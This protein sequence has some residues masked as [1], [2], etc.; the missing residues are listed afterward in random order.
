MLT[1]GSDSS[2]SC[3][4]HCTCEMKHKV[5]T[6]NY[7]DIMAFQDRHKKYIVLIAL[8]QYNII[9][10]CPAQLT[11]ISQLMFPLFVLTPVTLPP[12]TSTPFKRTPSNMSTPS[13]FKAS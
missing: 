13:K 10:T 1:V 4:D 6:I 11:N 12:S 7:Y 2:P 3:L 9:Y 8:N 5:E